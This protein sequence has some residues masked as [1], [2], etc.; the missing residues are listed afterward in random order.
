MP[1]CVIV[2][3]VYQIVC[4]IGVT[5]LDIDQIVCLIRIHVIVLHVDL[6]T[7]LIGVIGQDVHI[8]ACPIAKLVWTLTQLFASS[9]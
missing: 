7:C 2:L 8:F 5:I 3:H 6:I 9:V 4:R 1:H